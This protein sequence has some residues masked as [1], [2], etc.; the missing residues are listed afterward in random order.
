MSLGKLLKTA[1]ALPF[2]LL[3]CGDDNSAPAGSTITINPDGATWAVTAGTCNGTDVNFHA[4]SITVRN[5]AG[6]ELNNTDLYITLDLAANNATIYQAMQLYDDPNWQG[7]V[8]TVPQNPV[9]TPY[10]TKTGNSGTKRI[11][12]GVDLGGCGYKGSLNAY[13]GSSIDSVSIEVTAS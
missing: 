8:T 2:L 10:V 9:S 4:F 1:M 5:S 7:G 11:I 13:S 12:V 6:I 3:G